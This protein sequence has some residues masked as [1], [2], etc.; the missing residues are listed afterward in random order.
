MRICKEPWDH[1]EKSW[2]SAREVREGST[3]EESDQEVTWH[4][5]LSLC[6]LSYSRNNSPRNREQETVISATVFINTRMCWHVLW[7]LPLRER[8]RGH[9]SAEGLASSWS[10]DEVSEVQKGESW[11]RQMGTRERSHEARMR[12][13]NGTGTREAWSLETGS[14]IGQNRRTGQEAGKQMWMVLYESRLGK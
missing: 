3:A 2:K 9:R 8:V 11:W 13:A 5:V 12:T 1:R 14:E 7:R 6:N 4:L 10:R